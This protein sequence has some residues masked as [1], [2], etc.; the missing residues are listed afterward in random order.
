VLSRAEHNGV[1]RLSVPNQGKKL[2]IMKASKIITLGLVTA[3]AGLIMGTVA[4][5]AQAA[6]ADP[7]VNAQLTNSPDSGEH[8]NFWALNHL[9]RQIKITES[10]PHVYDVT[11][12]DSGRFSDRDRLGQIK[13]TE[14]AP[15]VYDVT[16]R[17]NGR[18]SDGDRLARRWLSLLGHPDLGAGARGN[19]TPGYSPCLA[20]ASD[21]DCRGGTGNGPKYT[22]PV[23]VTGADP[24][25]LDRDG[26]GKACMRS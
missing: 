23:R 16:A 8:G 14:N 11:V 2:D 25:K 9:N 10:S 7:V 20:P 24:Y 5:P 21:Y 19:C 6:A 17:D 18:F 1:D 13:I 3:S 12:G 4:L 26:N 22:G 15:G